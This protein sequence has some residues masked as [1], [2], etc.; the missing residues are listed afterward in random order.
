MR[1]IY[2]TKKY[3]PH[4]FAA[5]ANLDAEKVQAILRGMV[6]IAQTAPELL[7][8]IKMK[9]FEAAADRDWDDVRELELSASQTEIVEQGVVS[10]RFD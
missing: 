2:R 10:C 9:G 3:T 4:A 5:S 6:K 1:I 7:E 8:P